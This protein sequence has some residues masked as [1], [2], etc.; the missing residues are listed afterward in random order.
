MKSI[1]ESNIGI[2][3]LHKGYL[4]LDQYSKYVFIEIG[5]KSP[6]VLLY[7]DETIFSKS[8]TIGNTLN[9]KNSINK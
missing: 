9:I 1:V 5:T 7:I 2:Y 3:N 4:H 6:K 8:H